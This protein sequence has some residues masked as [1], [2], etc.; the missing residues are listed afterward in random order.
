MPL[1]LIN[2]TESEKDEGRKRCFELHFT[3]AWLLCWVS[4]LD[5]CFSPVIR[6]LFGAQVIDVEGCKISEISSPQKSSHSLLSIDRQGRARRTDEAGRRKENRGRKER[7]KETRVVKRTLSNRHFFSPSP[8]PTA[9]LALVA[10]FVSLR[11]P[12]VQSSPPLL[13]A[14]LKIP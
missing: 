9:S 7:W 5:P 11:P 1:R 6:R 13:L 10:N 8:L 2:L 12:V 14:P 3:P 4:L